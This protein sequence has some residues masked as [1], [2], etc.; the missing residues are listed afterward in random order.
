MTGKSKDRLETACFED[1]GRVPNSRLPVIIHRGAVEPDE[2]D[3]A[4][5]FERKFA[6]NNWKGSWRWNIFTF[7]H[8][9]ST[10]HEVLGIA[11]GHATLR[12]GGRKGRDFKVT[13]GDVIVLPAGTG[14]KRLASSRDFL[15]VGAYPEGRDRDLIKPYA[16]SAAVHDAALS[17]IAGVPLPK[18]DPVQGKEG[19]VRRLWR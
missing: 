6:E 19:A 16:T 12:L 15:V 7:H 1:D 14:H 17:R 13:A 18:T 4:R 5:A 2:E 3:P 11:V 9:H 10:S 8:Y